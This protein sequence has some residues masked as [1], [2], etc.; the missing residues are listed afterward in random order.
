MPF[1]R[2][3]HCT[4]HMYPSIEMCAP[5]IYSAKN[6][7]RVQWQAEERNEFLLARQKTRNCCIITTITATT[8]T[9][10]TTNNNNIKHTSRQTNSVDKTRKV[11]RVRVYEILENYVIKWTDEFSSSEWKWEWKWYWVWE[12]GNAIESGQNNTK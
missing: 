8:A 10:Q 7:L 3:T 12:M 6:A 2:F 9:D 5:L 11:R 1:I 4:T